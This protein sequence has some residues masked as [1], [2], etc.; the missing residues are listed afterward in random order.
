[1]ATISSAVQVGQRDYE[2]PEQWESQ[3]D[4]LHARCVA[5]GDSLLARYVPEHERR[6]I[7]GSLAVSLFFR[8]V[9]VV[10]R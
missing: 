4:L 9:R 1:M 3:I 8:G 2:R 5:L 6:V 10:S 7:M